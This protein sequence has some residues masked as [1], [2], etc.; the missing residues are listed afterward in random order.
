MWKVDDFMP[1]HDDSVYLRFSLVAV[2][3]VIALALFRRC[4]GGCWWVFLV[5]VSWW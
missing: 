2:L 4:D 1:C 5:R 3:C